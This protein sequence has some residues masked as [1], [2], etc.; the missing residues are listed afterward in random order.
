[1]ELIPVEPYWWGTYG[2][3]SCQ[4]ISHQIFFYDQIWHTLSELSKINFLYLI[5]KLSFLIRFFPSHGM[6]SIGSTL[7]TH[8]KSFS[9]VS[10]HNYLQRCHSTRNAF[11][12]NNAKWRT[13][14]WDAKRGAVTVCTS[15][16]RFSWRTA[17]WNVSVRYNNSFR[18]GI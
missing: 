11:S 5:G 7:H 2:N 1:M 18:R 12:T 16:N 4:K 6:S 13:A 14:A 17:R 9:R 3:T 8:Q 10:V 15:G